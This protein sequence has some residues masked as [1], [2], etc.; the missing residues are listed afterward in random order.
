MVAQR[1][2]KLAYATILVIALIASF[3]SCFIL[4]AWAVTEAV[5]AVCSYSP[6]VYDSVVYVARTTDRAF[7][8]GA[9]SPLCASLILIFPLAVIKTGDELSAI[10]LDA[11]YFEAVDPEAQNAAT[12]TAPDS[13]VTQLRSTIFRLTFF[14]GTSRRFHTALH[15]LS[16]LSALG[17][18]YYAVLSPFS[19][20][21]A[22]KGNL[23]AVVKDVGG[24]AAILSIVFLVVFLVVS[25][26]LD[27]K[28]G[29]IM[30][31]REALTFSRLQ[32]SVFWCEYTCLMSYIVSLIWM[33]ALSRGGQVILYGWQLA[34]TTCST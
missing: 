32:R 19:M 14:T 2:N 25:S 3:T 1:H 6:V 5:Q 13:H 20:A 28:D 27:G 11:Q 4:S 26:H 15:A 23:Q 22:N 34:V 33:A 9:I 30:T 29:Q 18:G 7:L 31:P 10:P 8:L 21:S 24:I 16:I 17:M 12:A